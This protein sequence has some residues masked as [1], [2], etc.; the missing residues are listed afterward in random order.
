MPQHN[1]SHAADLD[2]NSTSQRI[3]IP[4]GE[5]QASVF[6]DILDDDISELDEIFLL[7]LRDVSNA[8]GGGGPKAGVKLG[9][10]VCVI[11]IN[12]PGERRYQNDSASREL[13][14]V[15]FPVRTLF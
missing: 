1:D 12:Q 13:W 4:P 9:R 11:Y 15:N 7:H 2:Y 10:D 6:I 8:T 3:R 14:T 5:K